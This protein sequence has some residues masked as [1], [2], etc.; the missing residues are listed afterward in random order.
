[1][2]ACALSSVAGELARVRREHGPSAIMGGSQGWSSAGHFHEA[3]GQLRRFL[4][5]SGGFVDQTSN[6][7]FGTALTFLPHMR[8]PAPVPSRQ[9]RTARGRGPRRSPLARA[10]SSQRARTIG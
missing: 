2:T 10:S 1:V 8:V 5:A 7:S 3:R 6:Y 4:A 9:A